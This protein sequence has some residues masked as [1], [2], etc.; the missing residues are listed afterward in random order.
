MGLGHPI[1]V[2]AVAE[3]DFADQLYAHCAPNGGW[4]ISFLDQPGVIILDSNLAE[5]KRLKIPAQMQDYCMGEVAMSRD[6][7]LIALSTRTEMRM[8]DQEG[9]EI[10]Q[11]THQPW[12]DFTGSSC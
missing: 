11:I 5:V 8:Y 10:Y 7:Q 9:K 1:F 4:L 2:K 3:R 12:E 6:G